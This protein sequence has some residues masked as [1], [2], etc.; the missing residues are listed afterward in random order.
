MTY[1]LL[2]L[3]VAVWAVVAR[4]VLTFTSA[5]APAQLRTERRDTAAA[6]NTGNSLSL[7]YRDPFLERSRPKPMAPP[8]RSPAT[9]PAASPEMPAMHYKGI[10]RKD[11]RTYAVIVR[12]TSPET[13]IRGDRIDGYLVSEVFVDSIVL[14]KNSR[15]Y[16]VKID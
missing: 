8:V 7:D 11:N 10:I 6:A 13:V 3:A 4:R 16:T 12:G 9:V 5:D 15:K 14:L 2:I 1:L